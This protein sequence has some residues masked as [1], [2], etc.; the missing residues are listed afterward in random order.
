MPDRART[1][2]PLRGRLAGVRAGVGGAWARGGRRERVLIASGVVVAI[3]LA[4]AFLFGAWHVLFGGLVKN[5]WRAG[6]FGVVLAAVTAGLLALEASVAR[7]ILG[8][9]RDS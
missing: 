3:A 2:P 5:N 8:P 7:R 6:A 9:R 1:A 4:G